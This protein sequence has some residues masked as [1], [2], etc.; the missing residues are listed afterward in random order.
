MSDEHDIHDASI[1]LLT[2]T[3]VLGNPLRAR[4]AVAVEQAPVAQSGTAAAEDGLLAHDA[5]ALVERLRG[6]CLTWLTGDGRNVIEARCN[7]ALQEHTHWLVGHVSREIGLALETE[8]KGWVRAAVR[9]EL[10][11]RAGQPPAQS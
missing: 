5:D 8:L 2:D 6:R 3:L 11:A 9:E 10:A 4:V 7:A 1:P